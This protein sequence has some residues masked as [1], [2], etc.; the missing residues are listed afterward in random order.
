MSPVRKFLQTVGLHPL[1]AV[2]LV[3]VDIMLF[4][5]EVGSAG[6]GVAVSIPV[7]FVL[8]L[9]GCLLQKFSYGDNWGTA[10]GKGL[11]MGVLTAIPTSLPSV[12]TGG[13]GV[14]GL[15]KM[16]LPAPKTPDVQI[17]KKP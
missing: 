6:V 7:G 9:A 8:G 12:L 14:L 17:E 4:G 15:A 10:I 2:G 5:G 16:L 1:A 3:A 11:V 13:G